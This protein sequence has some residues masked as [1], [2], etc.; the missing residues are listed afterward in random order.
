VLASNTLEPAAARA[1]PAEPSRVVYRVKR[2][3]TLSSIARRHG[4]TVDSV[5]ALNRIRGTVI[6]VGQR[7][8]IVKP[9]S[10]ATN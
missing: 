6:Q 7:L 8:T 9:P 4:I 5:R 1:A 10:L 3:D 2:G